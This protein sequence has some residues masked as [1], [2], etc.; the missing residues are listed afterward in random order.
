MLRWKG[1]AAQVTEPFQRFLFP[2][3]RLAVARP[4]KPVGA[5]IAQFA[6]GT[7]SLWTR[8]RLNR[9]QVIKVT[10]KSV[11]LTALLLAGIVVG[12]FAF[13][14]SLVSQ[15]PRRVPPSTRTGSV[16]SSKPD[17]VQA[18]PLRPNTA[19]HPNNSDKEL[20]DQL[21][22]AQAFLA[23]LRAALQ[24][25]DWTSAPALLNEFNQ[26]T[27]HLPAPQLNQPDFSPV[28]QDFLTLY[29][30]ELARAL[31]EQNQ[32]NAQFCLNQLF[33]IVSEQQ[34][35]LG[36]HGAPLELVRLNY[37]VREISLWAQSSND[38]MLTER[39]KALQETWQELRP[40]IAAR[41]NGRAIALHFDSL[42]EQVGQTIAAPELAA[43]ATQC[44]PDL[45]QMGALFRRPPS[46]P[47][48]PV[49][50]PT[51]PADEE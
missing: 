12:S 44:Q 24:S 1:D 21:S 7:I 36:P 45:E 22:Q 19:V 3:H 16:A 34:A 4:T 50:N 15:P 31:H 47:A 42:L 37:L 8:L 39:R 41:R 5:P 35:R 9:M 49:A 2:P 25:S 32:A 28:M 43:L 51:K 46:H 23:E 26:R 6:A 10:N 20:Y 33:A 40:L 29:R 18:P 14:S 38:A 13:V 27:E 11:L 48:H 30:V 17:A